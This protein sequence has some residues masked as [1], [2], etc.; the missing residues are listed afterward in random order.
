ML[1]VRVAESN[2]SLGKRALDVVADGVVIW[3]M[4][5]ADALHRAVSSAQYPPV[6]IRGI[7]AKCA[8]YWGQCFPEHIGT[9][10]DDVLVVP[11]IE[12]AEGILNLPAMLAAAGLE[13][14]D[15]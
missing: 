6:G 14:N 12:S 15:C 1:L 3:W 9:A 4:E 2:A 8:T 10:N 5:S 13:G 7:G 11:N